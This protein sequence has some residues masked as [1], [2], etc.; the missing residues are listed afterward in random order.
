MVIGL[1][2]FL[3][4]L[5]LM[6]L[7]SNLILGASLWLGATLA[8]CSTGSAPAT[9]PGSPDAAAAPPARWERLDLAADSLVGGLDPALA[10]TSG[11]ATWMEMTGDTSASPRAFASSRRISAFLPEAR[12]QFTP[13]VTDSLAPALG[14]VLASARASRAVRGVVLPF[15]QSVVIGP[16][17][18]VY[19]ALNHYLGA[20]HE[21]YA[22]FPDYQRRLKTPARIPADVAEALL[23]TLHPFQDQGSA[24]TLLNRLLYEG[25]IVE[26]VMRATGLGEREALGYDDAQMQ[27]A[28]ANERAVWDALLQRR[29]L[30]S[31]DPD[32]S[33]RLL[34]PAPSTPLLTPDAPG[35]IGRFMGHRLVAAWL[36]AA[37]QNPVPT[38]TL[39]TPAFYLGPNTLAQARYSPR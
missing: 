15:L 16:D 18:T 2:P 5:S 33:A 30:F 38:D 28:V 3:L 8:A 9:A 6:Q 29:M 34:A 17:T 22:G 39:L 35:R 1:W 12:R 20:G 24:T 26:G 10:H 13:E 4:I 11:F 21:A 32:I 23:A 25:A 14:R 36:S 27:W 19:I 31:T 7:S 37:G